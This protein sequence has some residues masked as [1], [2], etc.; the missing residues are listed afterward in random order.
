MI[1]YAQETARQQADW[2]SNQ[3]QRDTLAFETKC[4][5]EDYPQAANPDWM[6]QFKARI[7]NAAESFGFYEGDIAPETPA[8]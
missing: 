3:I 7:T 8:V 1:Q 4:F 6:A 5:L 2:A